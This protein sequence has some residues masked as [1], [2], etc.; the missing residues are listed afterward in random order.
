MNQQAIF[1]SLRQYL[2]DEFPNQG[3][4][5]AGDTRLLDEWFVDSMGI[6]ETVI[7]IEREFGVTM[8]RADIN[9]ETFQDINSLVAFI[10]ARAAS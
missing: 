10:G 8:T 9:G 5:L 2:Q 7:F 6:I 4:E 3:I 1:D